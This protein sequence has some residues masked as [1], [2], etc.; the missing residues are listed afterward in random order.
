[1]R[2]RRVKYKYGNR[3]FWYKGDYVSP[4]GQ[5]EKKVKEYV[6]NR[7]QEDMAAERITI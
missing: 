5:N 1:M 2:K 6:Q 3:R 4:V 7:L